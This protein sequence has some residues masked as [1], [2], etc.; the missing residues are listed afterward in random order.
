MEP[1]ND[2]QKL[3]ILIFQA[4]IYSEFLH[5]NVWLAID[6]RETLRKFPED[7]HRRIEDL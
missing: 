2:A 7:D 5:E 4:S 3:I 6:C 1:V